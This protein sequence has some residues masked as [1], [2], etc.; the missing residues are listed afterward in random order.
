MSQTSAETSPSVPAPNHK[1]WL[2]FFLAIVPSLVAPAEP[3]VDKW[4]WFKL[5]LSSL[6]QGLLAVK[7]YQSQPSNT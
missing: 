5:L 6:Y 4:A 3:P 7:A 1:V 2:Y